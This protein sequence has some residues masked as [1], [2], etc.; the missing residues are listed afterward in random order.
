MV[1]YAARNAVLPSVSGVA[2]SLGFVVGGAIVTEAVFS[3]PGI[4]L[5]TANAIKSRDYPVLQ[6]A[7]LMI[8]VSVIVFNLLADLY[9]F[10]LDPR[11]TT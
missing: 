2:V 4:G 11:I 6:G 1:T 8:T 7:F 5:L 3:Y 9:Y 10:K